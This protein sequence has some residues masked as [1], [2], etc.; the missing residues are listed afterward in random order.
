[1]DPV[2]LAIAKG[3]S[4][5]QVVPLYGRGLYHP[6]VDIVYESGYRPV[7]RTTNVYDNDMPTDSGHIW[8]AWSVDNEGRTAN[9]YYNSSGTLVVTRNGPDKTRTVPP[10]NI[11][12]DVGFLYPYVIARYRAVAA[13]HWW[14]I[15]MLKFVDADNWLGVV[16]TDYTVR[17]RVKIDGVETELAQWYGYSDH[18]PGHQLLTLYADVRSVH[19]NASPSSTAVYVIINGNPP[20]MV[21]IP[22]DAWEVLKQ[23]AYVGIGAMGTTHLYGFVAGSIRG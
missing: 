2:T 7:T 18:A 19:A 13:P 17:L 15:V 20:Q 3:H 12:S 1:M 10:V 14:R 5:K 22:V 4:Y 11:I 6:E 8:S 9:L 16:T 23:E 21:P